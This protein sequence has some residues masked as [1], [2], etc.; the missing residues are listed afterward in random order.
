MTPGNP[1]GPPPDPP[2][3]PARLLAGLLQHLV[4]RGAFAAG[5]LVMA[6]GLALLSAAWVVGPRLALLERERQRMDT[7][8]EARLLTPYW[9]LDLDL[10][11]WQPERHWQSLLRAQP[12]V[13]A[14]Y[15]HAGATYRRGFCGPERG[16]RIR[17]ELADLRSVDRLVNGVPLR[18]PVDADGQPQFELR[19]RP[20]VRE[21]LATI[22]LLPHEW[23][24]QPQA[25][26]ARPA[27]GPARSALDRLQVELDQPLDWLL[28]AWPAGE[29]PTLALRLDPRAPELALPADLVA[30]FRADADPR[31]L[32]VFLLG[33]GLLIY[34]YG[35]SVAFVGLSR[36]R[37][38]GI[39]AAI[40]LAFP[41]WGGWSGSVL[42]RLAPDAWQV[43]RDM[44]ED[45][46]SPGSPTLMRVDPA[47]HEDLL[48]MRWP[49]WGGASAYGELVASLQ[50]RRPVP[51]PAD[52]DAV[53][54]ALNAQVAE[55][56]R[57]LDD[58]A[59]ST[60][61][62]TLAQAHRQGRDAVGLLYLEAARELA[63]APA[64]PAPTRQA[65][66]RFLQR[67]VL[68]SRLEPQPDQ[69]AFAARL[70]LWRRLAAFPADPAVA[71]LAGGV[72]ARAEARASARAA[73]PDPPADTAPN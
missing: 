43:G 3:R 22:P 6:I 64:R 40:L 24:E 1:H 35:L 26:D 36:G 44:A 12:C 67:L 8:V 57:R 55:R 70:D 37:Q 66:V 27:P 58:T 33:T 25:E 46:A 72:V 38:A 56:L 34:G 31:G 62:D 49:A 9:V 50:L 39:G 29:T 11:R 45:L 73:A 54:L 19:M 5:A 69:P 51:P 28:S 7:P 4:L 41:L 52:A 14:E 63:L 18:W 17:F 65:A 48:R 21:A 61:F 60:L 2:P 15:R 16:G 42:Q 23:P 59:A 13:I 71:T 20:A 10:E 68:S 32:A 53:L 30:G 47:V